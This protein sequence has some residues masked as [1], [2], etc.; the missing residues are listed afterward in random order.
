MN[1][2]LI[3]EVLVEKCILL[4]TGTTKRHLIITS[5]SYSTT[6]NFA[7][8]S[9]RIKAMGAIGYLKHEFGDFTSIDLENI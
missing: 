6:V 9:K 5:S 2:R 7:I 3:Q 8:C 1:E 4:E